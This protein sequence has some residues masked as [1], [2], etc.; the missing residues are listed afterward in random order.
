M[1][2]NP[3]R[4]IPLSELLEKKIVAPRVIDG[5]TFYVPA[6]DCYPETKTVHVS[7]DFVDHLR[8]QVS[9][10]KRPSEDD[11]GLLRWAEARVG[12]EDPGVWT[13]AQRRAFAR[14]AEPIYPDPRGAVE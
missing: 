7:Q 2:D 9:T 11:I 13:Q 10:K 5:I 4:A 6:A 14:M 1:S 12:E 8:R 3:V